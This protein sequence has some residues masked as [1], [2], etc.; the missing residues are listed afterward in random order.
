[1][2][3]FQTI[4]VCSYEFLGDSNSLNIPFPLVVDIFKGCKNDK[5]VNL[6]KIKVINIFRNL[7]YLLIQLNRILED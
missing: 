3:K 5:L 1:M 2:L 6:I 7:H 4:S